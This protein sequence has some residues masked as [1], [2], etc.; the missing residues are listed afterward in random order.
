MKTK[1]VTASDDNTFANFKNQV[2][3][4]DIGIITY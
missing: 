3:I 2:E 4:L 1:K